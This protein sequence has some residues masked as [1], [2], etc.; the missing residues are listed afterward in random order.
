MEQ[1]NSM[2]Q[3]TLCEEHIILSGEAAMER[4]YSVTIA[5]KRVVLELDNVCNIKR[6]MVPLKAWWY[7]LALPKKP[8]QTQQIFIV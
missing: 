7:T 4:V 5:H 2:P 6:N 3:S 1:E 8:G